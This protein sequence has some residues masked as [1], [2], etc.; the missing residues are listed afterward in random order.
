ML[1]SFD[2]RHRRDQIR[3]RACGGRPLIMD[4]D[5]TAENGQSLMVLAM[6][7]YSTPR[8]VVGGAF[9]CVSVPVNK[10]HISINV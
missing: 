7:P 5:G 6:S 9:G 10:L 3:A 4:R 8:V 1:R 2:A